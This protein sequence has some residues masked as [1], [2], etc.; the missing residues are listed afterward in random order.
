MNIATITARDIMTDKVL[1]VSDD[2]PV[3][4]LATFLDQHEITGAPVENADG[5]L[6]GVVSVVDVARAESEHSESSSVWD[7]LVTH[8][9]RYDWEEGLDDG[10]RIYHLRESQTKVGDIMNRSLHTADATT[11]VRELASRM[12]TFHVHRLLV[13]EGE[14]VVGIVSS[15]DL[16]KLMANA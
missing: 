16:L 4:D 9:Y 12:V 14:R 8:S 15:S 13:V 2:M 11:P 5:K 7:S 3:S 6:V 1:T 10:L